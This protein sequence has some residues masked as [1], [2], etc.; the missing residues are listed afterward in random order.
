[1]VPENRHIVSE[2]ILHGPEIQHKLKEIQNEYGSMEYKEYV[3]LFVP[4][5]RFLWPGPE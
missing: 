1:M 5:D 4:E 2:H 3:T